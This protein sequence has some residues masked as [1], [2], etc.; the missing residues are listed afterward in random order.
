MEDSLSVHASEQSAERFGTTIGLTDSDLLR[1]LGHSPEIEVEVL[2]AFN[3]LDGEVAFAT[4]PGTAAIDGGDWCG[5][6]NAAELEGMASQ[7]ALQGPGGAEGCEKGF[8]PFSRA[9][10]FVGDVDAAIFEGQVGLDDEAAP[11]KLDGLVYIL[12]KKRLGRLSQVVQ[13]GC[14]ELC[15]GVN[16]ALGRFQCG[17]VAAGSE[18]SSVAA[19]ESVAAVGVGLNLQLTGSLPVWREPETWSCSEVGS[20]EAAAIR[21]GEAVSPAC[22]KDGETLS[23]G[24]PSEG[25]ADACASQVDEVEL[26]AACLGIDRGPM[27]LQGEEDVAGVE[28]VVMDAGLMEFGD[29]LSELDEKATAYVP[30]V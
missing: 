17:I 30:L 11:V 29:E 14:G 4:V 5:C 13:C 26:V 23:D 18:C 24:G 12:P 28:I 8:P 20:P 7:P 27:V 16:A 19:T 15:E 22:F 10:A 3:P 6:G 25:A 21:P 1:V 9:V 2:G